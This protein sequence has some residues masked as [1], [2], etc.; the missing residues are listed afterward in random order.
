MGRDEENILCDAWEKED[1]LDDEIMNAFLSAMD[2]I[3]NVLHRI[4]KRPRERQKQGKIDRW[5]EIS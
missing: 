4:E 1:D 3:S 2:G 5:M